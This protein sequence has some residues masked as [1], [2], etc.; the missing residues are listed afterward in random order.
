MPVKL[1]NIDRALLAILASDARTTNRDL[2]R[3]VGLSASACLMRVRRLEATGV[4]IGYR[5][6]VAMHGGKALEG[7]ASVRLSEADTVSLE[8]FVHLVGTMPEIVEAH[9]MAGQYDFFLRFCAGGLEA[10]TR[11]RAELELLDRHAQSRFSIVLD[12]LKQPVFPG[13]S[14]AAKPLSAARQQEPIS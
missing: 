7:W 12:S 4:I 5:T 1:D 3:R 8:R 10:W 13:P 11:F 6:V 9:R 2:A 14:L